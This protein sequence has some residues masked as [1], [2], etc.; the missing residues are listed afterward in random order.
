M[1]YLRI[2]MTTE[3]YDDDVALRAYVLK[4]FPHL[5]TPLERRVIEYSVPIVGNSD[6]WKIQQIYVFLEERDGHVPDHEVIAAF[7]VP[8]DERKQRALDR[9]LA[10]RRGEIQENRCPKCGRLPRSPVARQ[11]LWCR[12]DWH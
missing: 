6:H 9:I 1:H 3:T 10:N 8:Y 11:C 2:P 4:Y 12:H 5:L 7:D